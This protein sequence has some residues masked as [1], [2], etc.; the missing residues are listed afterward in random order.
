[1][2]AP[3]HLLLCFERQARP[4]LIPRCG[5]RWRAYQR[6]YQTLIEDEHLSE[7]LLGSDFAKAYEEQIRLISTLHRYPG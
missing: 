4:P 2:F 1:A 3:G 6:H 7:R 5:A